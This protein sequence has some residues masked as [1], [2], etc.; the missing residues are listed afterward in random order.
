MHISADKIQEFGATEEIKCPRCGKAVNMN[1]LRATNG[2]GV[3]NVSLVNLNVD[4]FA[5]CPEC[6]SL[7]AVDDSIAKRAGKSNSNNFMMVNEKNIK[8]LRE[9]K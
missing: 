1:L 3:F 2:L 7:F 4:L 6:N 5:I 9:L 8:F